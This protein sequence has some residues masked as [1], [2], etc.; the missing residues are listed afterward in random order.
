[1][2]KKERLRTKEIMERSLC[3]NCRHNAGCLHL[4]QATGVICECELYECSPGEKSE[5]GN[6]RR[7]VV[8]EQPSQP[9]RMKRLTGLCVD[10]SN[11]SDCKLPL[12]HN[13]W[14]CEEYC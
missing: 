4:S 2:S 10:C 5:S 14:Q 8:Q 3:I 11:A 13:V 7:K 1:M 9:K 12:D 6:D